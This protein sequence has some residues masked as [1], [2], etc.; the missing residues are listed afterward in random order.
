[1]NRFFFSLIGFL[2]GGGGQGREETGRVGMK[3]VARGEV[4]FSVRAAGSS[5]ES[6]VVRDPFDKALNNGL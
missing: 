1:M 6:V 3:R 5:E 2:R 4:D